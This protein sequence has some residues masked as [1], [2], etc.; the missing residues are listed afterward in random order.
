M[1]KAFQNDFDLYGPVWLQ[2]TLVIETI[3]VGYVNF[4]VDHSAHTAITTSSDNKDA[5]VVQ[6]NS[7]ERFHMSSLYSLFMMVIVFY[8]MCPAGIYLYYKCG[9]KSTSLKFLRLYSIFAY[10]GVGYL[11]A[12]LLTLLPF[13]LLKW[14][15]VLLAFGN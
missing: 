11:P 2:V 3:I 13:N 12:V 15:A 9:L 10:S 1:L 4:K 6:A 5:V 7:T 8:N 14:V